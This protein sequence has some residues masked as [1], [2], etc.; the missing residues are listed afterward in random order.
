MHRHVARRATA[1]IAMGLAASIATPA[2]A[3]DRLPT[4]G[5]LDAPTAITAVVL[6][7][8]VGDYISQGHTW[9]FVDPSKIFVT[10]LTTPGW[11]RVSVQSSWWIDVR[12]P[13]ASTL[14]PGTYENAERASFASPG[15]PGLDVY[16]D[17]RGCNTVSGRF[18]V[19]EATWGLDGKPTVF[20][21]TLEQHCEGGAPALFVE[22]RIGST[23]PLAALTADTTALAFGDQA[24]GTSSAPQTATYTSAG[25]ADV[26]I[27]SVGLVFSDADQYTIAT[28]TCSGQ[29]LAPGATCSVSVRFAP[30]RLAFVLAS[31][32][33]AY[34]GVHDGVR[35]N[36]QGN[37]ILGPA[38]NDAIANAVV[39]DSVPFHHVADASLVTTDP[40][41]PACLS[42]GPTA[43]YRFTPTVTTQYEA[44]TAASLFATVLCVFKGSPGSLTLVE[45]ND[46]WNGTQQ[47]RVLFPGVIGTTY[48]LMVGAQA[49]YPPSILD[50]TLAVGPPDQVVSA[51]GVG[52]NTSTFY[53]YRDAYK[54]T[55]L[56]RG[57]LGEWATVKVAIY[58][59]STN[60]KVRA[61]DLGLRRGAYSVAW[62]GL[63]AAGTR[64]AAARY[65]VVQT[66]QD[67]L[68]NK[69][70]A[71]AYTTVS[72]KRLYTYSGSKT[73]Y[74]AQYSFHGDP[75]NGSI[76]TRS[77]FYRGI[78]VTSGSSWA[79]VGYTFS[80]P[81]ATVYKSVTFKVLGKSPNARQGWQAVWNPSRGSYLVVESYD[82]AK[83][84]GPSYRW[85]ST[86]GSLATHQ[87]SR[88][89]RAIV[90]S[91]YEG[92]SVTF[93]ISKVQ[94]SYTYGVLR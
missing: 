62:N 12:A 81:A 42:H 87:R 5:A 39:V 59:A 26:T 89:T 94:L 37:P 47:S 57:T 9:T 21:A 32:D 45:A 52:V 44:S 34:Q 48:Y 41:D 79:G 70:T 85:W 28:D 2:A 75:G 38:S 73:L 14:V 78:K 88:V 29:T 1:L 71:V 66:L 69:L 31:L 91:I 35:V 49:G 23:R 83:H 58:N 64:V 8:E 3:A 19:H 15:H 16:G 36:L 27:A 77:A 4:A 82:L 74:G 51:T 65:K 17:G 20:S 76:S 46:D 72:W 43:W 50:L 90:M 13:D 61:F 63:T 56:I 80:L 11:L 92:G 55:V 22:L 25:N 6:D 93:D 10:D 86:G 54:D 53:P 68:G 18:T 24:I 7:G 30:T 40:S 84:I 67:Q 33:V 60:G